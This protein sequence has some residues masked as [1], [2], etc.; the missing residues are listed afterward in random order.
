MKLKNTVLTERRQTQKS[1]HCMI[2]LI[3]NSKKRQNSSERKIS[4]CWEPGPEDECR[5]LTSKL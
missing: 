1:T 2:S 4:G 3:H 5:K